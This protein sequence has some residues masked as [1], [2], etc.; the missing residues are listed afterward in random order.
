MTPSGESNYPSDWDSRRRKVYSRDNHKCQNCDKK[1][2]MGGDAELHAHHIV[3]ISK[4]GSHRKSNLK[5][6]CKV[7]HD[8]IHGKGKA[9]TAGTSVSKMS[10]SAVSIKI[11]RR[12]D[13]CQNSVTGSYW[14]EFSVK[15]TLES[16]YQCERKGSAK[17]SN[18]T[19]S[20]SSSKSTPSESSS[21]KNDNKSTTS[22]KRRCSK[23]GNAVSRPYWNE[24]S[25]KGCLK[26]CYH[27]TY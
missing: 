22:K 13:N 12:C 27:C 6:L 20:E 25:E 17:S 8:A 2:R 15:G 18:S 10:K 3:P 16:C 24:F 14:K 5:T 11:Q 19:P 9:R 23:C 4:G 1:G 7:C 21:N 26:S